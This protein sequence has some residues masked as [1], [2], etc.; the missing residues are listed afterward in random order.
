[1]QWFA[2]RAYNTQALYGFGTE[3][4]AERFASHLNETRAINVYAP[5]PLSDA[6]AVELR[7]EDNSEAFNIDDA[8]REIAAV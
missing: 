8:L 4:E 2:F 5:Y 6:E 1:M 7:V 3:A